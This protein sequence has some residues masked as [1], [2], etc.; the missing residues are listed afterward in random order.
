MRVGAPGFRG[1]R[2]HMPESPPAESATLDA[3]ALRPAPHT[4]VQSLSSL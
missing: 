2:G 3:T 1:D 4:S